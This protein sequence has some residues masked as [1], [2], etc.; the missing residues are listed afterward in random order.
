MLIL[1][2]LLNGI[3]AVLDTVLSLLFFVIIGRAIVS[4]VNA[5]PYNG[6]VRFLHSTTEPLLR[7]VRRVIPPIGGTMDLSPIVLMIAIT[8]LQS[9]LSPLIRD[10]AMQIRRAALGV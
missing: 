8:L 2:H 4:W 10:Y 7:P 1:A 5:D 3:A 9:S 6:I